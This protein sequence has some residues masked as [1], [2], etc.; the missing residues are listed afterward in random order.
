MFFLVA[1]PMVANTIA[2]RAKN[3]GRVYVF[4]LLR[5]CQYGW[6]DSL[7]IDKVP[8][9]LFHCFRI[10]VETMMISL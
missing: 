3:T 4:S 10:Q 6:L 2:L 5:R 8:Y 9:K 7:G 1:D